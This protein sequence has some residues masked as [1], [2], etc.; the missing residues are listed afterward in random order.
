AVH[1]RGRL[2]DVVLLLADRKLSRGDVSGAL[3]LVSD[4]NDELGGQPDLLLEE[5]RLLNVQGEAERALKSIDEARSLADLPPEGLL[6]WALILTRLDR[7]DEGAKVLV[8]TARQE[9]ARERWRRDPPDLSRAM[10][11]FLQT[12]E[13]QGLTKLLESLNEQVPGT[14]FI[15][16]D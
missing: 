2:V 16:L 11:F 9:A 7:V 5:A 1:E 3:K 13:T 4:Y 8:P 15:R 12:G 6:L 14:R 10:Q